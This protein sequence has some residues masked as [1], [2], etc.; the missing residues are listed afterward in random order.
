MTELAEW[1]PELAE[2]IAGIKVDDTPVATFWSIPKEHAHKYPFKRS[3]TT[4][5]NENA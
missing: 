3:E 4:E 1:T 2:Q 5:E